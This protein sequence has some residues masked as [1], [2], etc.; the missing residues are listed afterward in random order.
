MN[1]AEVAWGRWGMG[2]LVWI[3]WAECPGRLARAPRVEVLV[4]VNEETMYESL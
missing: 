4:T 1:P 2:T 3:M